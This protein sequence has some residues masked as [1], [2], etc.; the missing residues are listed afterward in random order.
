M[1][2]EKFFNGYCRNIDQ[3][4]IVSVEKNDSESWEA[5]CDYSVCPYS[6]SC[7]IGKEISNLLNSKKLSE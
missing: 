4:R 5:D 6:G 7:P 2:D 1:I 3:S